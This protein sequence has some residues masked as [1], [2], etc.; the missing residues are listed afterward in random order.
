MSSLIDPL[1]ECWMVDDALLSDSDSVVLV[2]YLVF[3]LETPKISCMSAP[4]FDTRFIG[5]NVPNLVQ[6]VIG[7]DNRLYEGY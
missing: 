3:R 4:F 5:L 6:S 2:V 7:S 1:I